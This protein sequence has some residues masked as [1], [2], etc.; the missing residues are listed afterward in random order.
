MDDGFQFIIESP[1][2]S[3]GHKKRPRLVTSCDNCRLKKIKCL[4]PAPET[5]CEACKAAKVA[6]RFKDRERYFAERSRAIAGP[7]PYG[8]DASAR[9]T[10]TSPK[11]SGVVVPEGDIHSRRSL[12]TRRGPSTSALQ[13]QPPRNDS[14]GH[15][16]SQRTVHLFDPER[17]QFPHPTYMSHFIQLF[18]EQ[19]ASEFP[20]ITYDEL[21]RDF[22]DSLM[23][24][25]MAN[26]I[27]S[28]ATRY[29]TL[30]DLTVRGLHNVAETYAEN[31]KAILSSIVHIPSLDT[32]HG[33]MLLSWS[34]YKNN[35]I[36]GLRSYC[37]MAMRMAIDI[38]LSDQ[39][40][41]ASLSENERNR[42]RSTWASVLQLHLTASSCN[43]LIRRINLLFLATASV[44]HPSLN[45]NL[46]HG[47]WLPMSTSYAGY[48]RTAALAIAA[49][50]YLQTLPFECRMLSTAWRE[51][52]ISLSF[53]LFSLIR[54]VSIAALTVSN[55]GF[56]SDS[57]TQEQCRQYFLVPSVFKGF[58]A[59]FYD[60]TSSDS[61]TTVLQ[62]MVSQAI[63]AVRAYNLSRKSANIGVML[64]SIYLI[65]CT[66]EWITTLHDRSIGTQVA[67]NSA[68]GNCASK[69]P[70]GGLGGWVHYAVAI[71]YDFVT[72]MFCIVFLLKLRPA[73]SSIMARVVRM[74]LVDGLWYFLGLALVNITNLI[75]Y[76][77][78]NKQTYATVQIAVEVQTAGASM[79]YAVTWIMSSKLIIHLHEASL[80]GRNESGDAVTVTRQLTSA[81]DVSRAIRSQFESKN[82]DFT[83]PD[84]ES[85]AG[86]LQEDVDVQVRVEKTVKTESV[87][88]AYELEDYSRMARS[89][90][91]V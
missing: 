67:Y 44:G 83:I 39:S 84:M 69:S 29:S 32:L 23:S 66:L 56:F 3:Q 75:F 62:A 86:D 89:S 19:L 9:S 26:C 54:Y 6:C 37:Q 45:L 64:L 60:K 5:K 76:R 1:Q 25:L 80:K 81:R 52:R 22:W 42:R 73:S 8:D 2:H 61:K 41:L 27:A 16:P 57:F 30:T 51:R 4:Q 31:A 12:D 72:S 71:I 13:P 28:M 87:A 35:R 38:G 21:S 78:I 68:I 65:C 63:L 33:V 90:R 7:S 34:E 59:Q 79:G 91:Y 43:P 14:I 77:Q 48:L 10:T 40:L 55:V 18:F 74:M 36:S 82:G 20:F 11:P 50:D 58:C 15:P 47:L 85:S 17:P 49:Y 46:A 70:N 88:R 53:I 24:P